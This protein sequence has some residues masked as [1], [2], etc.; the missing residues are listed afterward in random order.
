VPPATGTIE[1]PDGTRLN[2]F[3]EGDLIEAALSAK[4]KT[5]TVAFFATYGATDRFDLGVAVPILRVDLDAS[6]LATVQRLATVN[7]PNIHTFVRGDATAV[8]NELRS[9]G[10]AS[11]L[12]DVVVRAK[13]RLLDWAGGG[14]LAAAT[15][16][17]LP[18]G[19]AEDLLGGAT[20]SK[21]Y[22]VASRASERLGQHV[23]FGY[24]FS[25]SVGRGVSE[26]GDLPDE[27]NYAAG[28]EYVAHPKLTLIGDIVG[29]SL[30]DAARLSVQAKT[31]QFVQ[32]TGGPVMSTQFDEFEP[33]SGAL[34]LLFGTFGAKFN[35]VGNLLISGSVLFP[36]TD[37]GLRNRL[38]T[39][40]G[41]DYAF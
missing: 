12:G 26:L 1:E 23:N 9:Q 28:A 36:L 38:T 32:V 31:F 20:Q 14:G 13:Y 34:N 29:R 33:R 6:V 25:G 19:D 41:I 37:G 16:L 4:V 2:P 30:P 40:I 17:R 24:T 10:S 7:I 27:V 5:D 11:G 8:S 35:P 21:V 18:T 15:D 3:F 39:T 22:V